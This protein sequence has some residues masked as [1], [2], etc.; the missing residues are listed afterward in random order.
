MEIIVLAILRIFKSI[1]Q[2]RSRGCIF[3]NI[4]H[5]IETL[6]K[7]SQSFGEDETTLSL[8]KEDIRT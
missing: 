8:P 3:E 7:Q 6:E 5:Y 4:A 1:P 2:F